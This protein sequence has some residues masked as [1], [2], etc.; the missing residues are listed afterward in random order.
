MSFIGTDF[1]NMI[2]YLMKMKL[3][4]VKKISTYLRQH[5]Y[6]VTNMYLKKFIKFQPFKIGYIILTSK[7]PQGRSSK[8][9]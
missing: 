6:T 7:T 5:T 4:I 2:G 1:V 8:G 3:V 9:P